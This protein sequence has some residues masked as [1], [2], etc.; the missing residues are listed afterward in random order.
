[1]GGPT[2]RVGSCPSVKVSLRRHAVPTLT[3]VA[4]LGVLTAPAGFIVDVGFP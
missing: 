4:E 3:S 2:P 1:M